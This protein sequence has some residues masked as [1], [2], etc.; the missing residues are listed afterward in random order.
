MQL[1][2]PY[3]RGGWNILLVVLGLG[4]IVFLH[5]LGHFLLAKKN[6]VRVEAFSLGFG[7]V[8]WK[9]RHGDTEYRL[10]AFPLGGYVKMAGESLVDDRRGEPW[11]LTS[12]TPWQRFQIFVAGA[13][14]NL[15]IAFPIAIG[16]YAVGKVEPTNIVGAP[17]YA[18]SL[19]GLRPGD[20]VLQV[21]DR[22]IDSLEKM[23]PEMIRRPNGTVVPVR[24][25]RVENGVEVEKT[26]EV[27]ARSSSFHQTN[28]VMTMI[29]GLKED[30]AAYK[31]GLRDSDMIVGVGDERVVDGVRVLEILRESPDKD[32]TLRVKR[33]RSDWTTEDVTIAPIKVPA[34]HLWRI[35]TDEH[36]FEPL[37][38]KVVNG[39]AAWDKLLPG[40]RITMVN[41]QPVR[42]WRDMKKAV[43]PAFGAEIEIRA[44]R[45]KAGPVSVRL[46]PGMNAQGKGVLGIQ[47]GKSNVV[48]HVEPGSYYDKHGLKTGD[49]LWAIGLKSGELLIPRE[50]FAEDKPADGAAPPPVSVTVRRDGKDVHLQ[51]PYDKA[52]EG[53]LMATGLRTPEGFALSDAQLLRERTFG[54]AFAAGM[55]EPVDVTVWT[56]EILRKLVTLEESSKGLSGPIGIFH[57]TFRS[58]E[59]S[60]GNFLWLLCLI[61]VNLGI[62]NLLPIPVLDGGHNV[63]LL[64]EV[65]RKWF[66]KP[67][68]SE[69]FVATFQYSGLLFILCLFVMVTFN[70]ISRLWGG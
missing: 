45:P 40:D 5:E 61:T 63:L 8:L 30:S 44:D 67:P 11:E 18:E 37:V 35:P 62:F 48:A 31:A 68:P 26:L 7:P 34:R 33:W 52:V 10:S 22:K 55:R 59:R 56:F 66:G 28:T 36:L 58:V 23:L 27:V 14:M 41:G 50:G 49:V 9:R 16:A 60:F 39:T 32:V 13:T 53:D 64:I 25:K 21:G 29:R 38:G 70:D 43:E 12:K 42:S 24:V 57:V 17:G 4:L 47:D 1:L 54:E 20:Q 51:F 15:I 69:K 65:I 3:L 19:G 2:E 6:K 46:R